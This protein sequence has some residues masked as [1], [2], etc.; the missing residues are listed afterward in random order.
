MDFTAT[1]VLVFISFIAGFINGISGGG[2]LILL[3]AFLLTG[4]P[5]QAAIG[6]NKFI[7]IIGS[8][9]AMYNYIKQ[10]LV[11]LDILIYGSIHIILGAIIGA[12]IASAIDEQ[13]F[14]KFISLLF[15]IA[16]IFVFYIPSS[17]NPQ[18]LLDNRPLHMGDKYIKLPLIGL[19]IGFYNG[20]FGPGT[21]TLIALCLHYFIKIDIVKSLGTAALLNWVSNW[22]AVI[23]F[24][25]SDYIIFSTG[26]MLTMPSILGNFIGSKMAIRN[27]APF[28]KK[29]LALALSTSFI[30]I[31]LKYWNIANF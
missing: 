7:A 8:T 19:L 10:S 4:L 15:P 29:F 3:G 6:T 5:P 14:A 12:H 11:R 27:G 16:I 17:S 26:I 21:I 30:Y 20:I 31:G 1:V 28:I 18:S 9:A 13:I 25:H 24:N 2:G 23:S 22:G